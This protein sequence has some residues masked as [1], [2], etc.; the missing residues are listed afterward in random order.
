MRISAN[1][2]ETAVALLQAKQWPELV[3]F[4]QTVLA[5]AQK[6]GEAGKA[7]Q[8]NA[9]YF[10]GL[11]WAENEPDSALAAYLQALKLHPDHPDYL[12]Q[13]GHLLRKIGQEA[14][15]LYYYQRVVKLYPDQLNARFNLLQ[16]LLQMQAWDDLREQLDLA[17]AQFPDNSQLKERETALRISVH[18]G[19][20]ETA[21]KNLNYSEALNHYQQA[22]KYQRGTPWSGLDSGLK[23]S[24]PIAAFSTLPAEMSRD[25][26]VHDIDQ[27]LW[28]DQQGLLPKQAQACLPELQDLLSQH[29][30]ESCNILTLSPNQHSLLSRCFNAP[31]YWPQTDFTGPVLN[32]DLNFEALENSFLNS[33]V[34]L[35]WFDH[36][37]STEAL[38]RLRQFCLGATLWRDYYA[39]QGY[40]GAFM[41]DGFVSPLLLKIAQELQQ[42][43]PQI[44]GAKALNYLWGF[45][46][47]ASS[48]G[49]RLHAD[50]AQINL[51]FWLTPDCANLNPA[52]GG[53]QVYDCSAPTD[54]NFQDYNDQSSQARIQA[55]L[56]HSKA[57]MTQIPHRQNRAVLFHSRLF[58]RTDPPQF[59]Q[60]YE[61]RRINV[62]MLFG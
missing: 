45:K 46:Y 22:F 2:I 35:L 38:N 51:N 55:Y 41:D 7:D 8:A 30:E 13:T 61:N 9:H 23:I 29:T 53:L 24:P 3:H 28:L 37:L 62:T 34:P 33:P 36:F 47:G 18:Q 59:K 48:Q 43:F 19:M 14:E 50:Q 11:A 1:W 10:M 39:N 4:A 16:M 21:L 58:H 56:L 25:K 17:L 26:W 52:G 6:S 60:G 5:Q 44:L 27:W 57:Q 42:A 12:R 20:A 15:A 40:L 32:P 54:W 49:I 31:V